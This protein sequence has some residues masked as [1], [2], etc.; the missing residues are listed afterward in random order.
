MPLRSRAGEE[1][2]M[3]IRDAT[4]DDLPAILAIYNHAI[5]T[6]NAVYTETPATLD[7]RRA[8]LAARRMQN[9][10]VLVAEAGDILGFASFGEFR[11]WPGYAAT[12]EHSVFVLEA[13]Q[14]RGVGTALLQRLID[15]ARHRDKHVMIAGIDAANTPSI[16]MHR[17]LGFTEAGVLREVARKFGRWLDLMLM[18][19]AM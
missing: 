10:P 16:A 19:R 1:R 6:S 7:D 15:E 3:H 17:K 5:L 9:F 12:V 4:E 14:R 2:S 13:A 18:Q 11:P 8:W